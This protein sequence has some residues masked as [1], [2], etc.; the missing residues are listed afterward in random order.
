MEESVKYPIDRLSIRFV[1]GDLRSVHCI[2]NGG[3][4]PQFNLIAQS[5]YKSDLLSNLGRNVTS[6]VKK[7]HLRR[8][9]L[10]GKIN[11]IS[12]FRT[13]KGST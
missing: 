6:L 1:G 12:L 5:V 13:K 4:Y 10:I 3:K 8:E 9:N 2:L 7:E 11:Q